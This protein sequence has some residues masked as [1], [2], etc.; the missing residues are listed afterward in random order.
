VTEIIAGK[1]A[2]LGPEALDA[3]L[4]ALLA[5]YPKAATGRRAAESRAAAD[6]D[7]QAVVH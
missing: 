5:E 4:N 1:P 2:P 3:A 6:D 7:H